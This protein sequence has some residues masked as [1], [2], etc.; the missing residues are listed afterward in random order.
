MNNYSPIS[1]EKHKPSP[2]TRPPTHMEKKPKPAK[3]QPRWLN[4]GKGKIEQQK[5]IFK[6]VTLSLSIL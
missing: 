1:A 4:M 3:K 2:F 6:K 5:N